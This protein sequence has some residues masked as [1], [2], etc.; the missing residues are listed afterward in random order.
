MRYTKLL[1]YVLLAAVIGTLTAC[2]KGES[3]ADRLN[4]ERNAVNAFLRRQRVVNEVP[5]D[6]KFEMGEDAPFY[7]I[8]PDGNVYMQVLHAS[9][10]ETDSATLSMPIYFR[11]TRYNILQ[12]YSE[13]VWRTYSDNATD[14]MSAYSAYF[15]F[16]DYTLPVSSQWGYG[17]QLPLEFLGVEG[18]EV[19]LVVK[20]QYGF[21]NEISYVLPFLFHIRYFHSTI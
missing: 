2:S 1:I 20:S 10:L 11:Y 12:W 19:R 21:T 3:Y 14:N 6:N 9:D 4:K 15:N 18:T 8:D 13:G 16:N 17:I 7:R 5:E